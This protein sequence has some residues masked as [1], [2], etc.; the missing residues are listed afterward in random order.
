MSIFKSDPM[1]FCVL[2]K[3]NTLTSN[4]FQALAE[5]DGNL[6]GKIDVSDS[7]WSNLKIWRD[8]DGDGMIN[9]NWE[10]KN[11]RVGTANR[12]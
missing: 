1:S 7:V 12:C 3:N 5:W 8:F 6:D 2:L 11:G 9:G 4:G 10:V